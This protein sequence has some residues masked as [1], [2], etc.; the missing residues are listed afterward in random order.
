[1]LALRDAAATCQPREP[2]GTGHKQRQMP[3]RL[4]ELLPAFSCTLHRELARIAEGPPPEPLKRE[5]Q[6]RIDLP[7]FICSDPYKAQAAPSRMSDHN[8]YSSGHPRGWKETP[9]RHEQHGP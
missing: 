7:M 1:M 9:H 8:M 2:L 5:R 6:V 4:N 3:R